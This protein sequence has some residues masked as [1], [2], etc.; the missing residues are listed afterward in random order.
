[1]QATRNGENKRTVVR[2]G[3]ELAPVGTPISSEVVPEELNK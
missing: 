2:H 1:M 3:I